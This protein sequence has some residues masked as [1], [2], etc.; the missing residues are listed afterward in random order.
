M[1]VFECVLQ[2]FYRGFT[3]VFYRSPWG[4]NVES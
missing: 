3:G 4:G 2:V 1:F